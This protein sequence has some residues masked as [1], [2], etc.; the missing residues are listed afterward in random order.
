MNSDI[1]QVVLY[2]KGTEYGEVIRRLDAVLAELGADNYSEAVLKLLEEHET[3][4]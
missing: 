4:V 3:N 2:F 1:K